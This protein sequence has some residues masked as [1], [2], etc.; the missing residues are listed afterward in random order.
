MVLV[1]DPRVVREFHERVVVPDFQRSVEW[2]G[3]N[4]STL[5]G[6]VSLR[7]M[8]LAQSLLEKADHR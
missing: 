3:G 7:V 2:N 4:G 8:R 1:E 6:R 5:R